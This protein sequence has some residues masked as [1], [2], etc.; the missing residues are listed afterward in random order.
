MTIDIFC[1]S[2]RV[3]TD[4]EMSLNEKANIG[5]LFDGIAKTY[6]KFN[7]V[8]SL[9]IDIWWRNK[10]IGGMKPVKSMLDVAIGTGD[11]A[12][13][14]IKKK[15]AEHVTGIDLSQAMMNIGIEKVTKAGMKGQV[16]F[17]LG[18]ALDMPYDDCQFEAVTC[19]YGIR[20]FSDLDRGLSEMFRVMK[21]GGQL[22]ILEFSYPKNPVIRWGY[23]LYF[24]HIMPWLGKVISNDGSAYTYF[25]NSV[26]QFIWGDEM[27]EHLRDAG[28]K[29]AKFKTM[30][31]GITTLYT[32]TK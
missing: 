27:I 10:A 9:G 8:T 5:K 31:F 11:V 30:T 22:V 23:D 19:A 15:K 14:A 1:I 29:N 24:S 20:N 25:L 4:R 17:M 16:D 6:D 7:H 13:T 12:M 28:F 21:P 2:L 3:K 32:A 18:S 26:K